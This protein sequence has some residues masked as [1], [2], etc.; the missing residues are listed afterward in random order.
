MIGVAYGPTGLLINPRD[1]LEGILARGAVWG[2]VFLGAAGYY[3]RTLQFSEFLVAPLPG[4]AA[5]FLLNGLVAVGWMALLISLVHLACRLL[6]HRQGH[7]RDLFCLWGYTQVPAIILAAL[8]MAFLSLVPATW[9]MELEI[10][11]IALGV[12]VAV[13]LSLWGLVLKFQAV[14]VCYDLSGRRLFQ[15]IVLAFALYGLVVWAEFAFVAERGFVPHR[16]LPAMTPTVLPLT[17][18]G[19]FI[20]LPFGKLT[21]QVRPPRRGEIVGFVA[22]G[23]DAFPSV[24]V[25]P[26]QRLL[27]RVV[28]LPSEEVEVRRG[29]VYLN[30]RPYEEPY[31]LGGTDLDVPPTRVPPGH[32][33]V[34]GDNRDVPLMAYHG[35]LVPQG[36]IRGRMSEVGGL[37]QFLVG[38]GRW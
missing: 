7:W 11:W 4:K 38:K 18:G 9:R 31:R 8:V 33:F 3:W 26:R 14:K 23:W 15:V 22:P 34:L 20:S 1:T 37:W 32:Y 24:I 6:G 19:R 2:S 28:G 5:V 16:A 13:L 12:A 35:G 21:Y 25:R 17:V 29:Q 10:A 27:G 30:G 36:R